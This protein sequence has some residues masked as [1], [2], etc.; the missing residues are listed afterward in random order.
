MEEA[1]GGGDEESQAV[2]APAPVAEPA[3]TSPDYRDLYLRAAAELENYRKRA[4]RDRAAM[5]H[6]AAEGVVLRLLDP[7]E[8]LERAVAEVAR[9]TAEAPPEVQDVLQ[10]SLEGLRA[11]KRQLSEVLAAEGVE[12][13]RAENAEFDP[14][15]HE[16]L[17]Q[18]PHPTVPSGA[19]VE[20]LRPGFSMRGKLLRPARVAVSAGPPAPP[21][22]DGGA[23]NDAPRKGAQ[24]KS[25]R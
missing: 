25:H 1:K 7:Y 23:S 22:P 24:T 11:L 16:A 15:L 20:L 5:V 21:S 17:V 6:F 8:S 9:V 2:Q 3:A 4:E 10:R 14:T 12:E 13:I 19:V 18:L